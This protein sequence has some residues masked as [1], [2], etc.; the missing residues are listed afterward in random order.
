MKES[1][2]S[3]Q[4]ASSFDDA[5]A[6]LVAEFSE[7]VRDVSNAIASEA[8]VPNLKQ[9]IIGVA[10][11]NK[12][13]VESIEKKVEQKL[14]DDR[15]KMLETL[16][17]PI[18]EVVEAYRG[19]QET[20]AALAS[21]SQIL[22]NM[23]LLASRLEEVRKGTEALE[24]ARQQGELQL[25]EARRHLYETMQTL[26]QR[27]PDAARVMD[28]AAE[29][30]EILGKLIEA[31]DSLTTQVQTTTR[32]LENLVIHRLPTVLDNL[33]KTNRHL[34]QAIEE[35]GERLTTLV[36]DRF[37]E[38]S[39]EWSQDLKDIHERVQL[40]DATAQALLDQISRYRPIL[41]F[42]GAG[43]IFLVLVLVLSR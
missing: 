43:A 3:L 13:A 29:N 15:R 37:R 36:T 31:I 22:E 40:L 2:K 5:D 35:I 27:I 1:D 32:E 7:L 17:N 4:A 19:A 28:E 39:R 21:S 30:R 12:R 11:A 34:A 26:D 41:L 20:L 18:H 16:Q 10:E 9:A 42:A 33:E 25:E 8:V 24:Q 14:A 6:Q 23:Q 38:S